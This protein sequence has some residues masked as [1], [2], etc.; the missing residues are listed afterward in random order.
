MKAVSLFVILMAAWLVFVWPF[1]TVDG[2]IQVSWE[3]IGAGALASAVVIVVMRN[4]TH[5][6]SQ[7]WINPARYFWFVVYLFV[8][9]WHVIKAN[10]DLAYRVLHPDMPI[11][12]GVVKVKTTLKTE[13]AITCLCNSITLTP[14]TH[15]VDALPDGTIFVHW[16]N[17]KTTDPVEATRMIVGRF[18]GLVRRIWE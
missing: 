5:H 2:A 13:D 8:F 3:D 7:V 10:L 17:V 11:K 9:V 16:I 15:V 4:V 18:E 12:P 1:S 6:K 14:G